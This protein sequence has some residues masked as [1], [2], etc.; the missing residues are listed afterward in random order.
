[1]GVY[2]DPKT[3]TKE[4][5]LKG[6]AIPWSSDKPWSETPEGHLPVFLVDNGSFTAAAIAYSEQ[7][8]NYFAED[9]TRQVVRFVAKIADLRGVSNL[10][11]YIKFEERYVSS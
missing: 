5:W 7:E 11:S 9:R 6:H 3:G 1:M 10:D 4:N 8:F 2:I